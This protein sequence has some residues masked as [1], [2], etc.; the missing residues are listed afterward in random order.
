MSRYRGF[1]AEQKEEYIPPPRANTTSIDQ[2]KFRAYV[3]NVLDWEPPSWRQP[4]VLEIEKNWEK[5][6]ILGKAVNA[7]R[8]V[9]EAGKQLA[10]RLQNKVSHWGQTIKK[11]GATLKKYIP[12]SW[13]EDTPDMYDRRYNPRGNWKEQN[14]FYRRK[15]TPSYLPDEVL[16]GKF[17]NYPAWGWPTWRENE[18]IVYEGATDKYKAVPFGTDP[19]LQNVQEF[20]KYARRW[21]ALWK[22]RKGKR[23]RSN[24]WRRRFGYS[25]RRWKKK[26]RFNKPKPK[27]VVYINA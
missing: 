26:R 12:D 24:R 5:P 13:W 1:V 7:T 25:R 21:G 17:Y 6:E 22:S 9:F 15:G 10:A 4:E 16:Y 3:R 19:Y 11:A 23:P 14:R 20:A 27:G 8:Y 2:E 18:M